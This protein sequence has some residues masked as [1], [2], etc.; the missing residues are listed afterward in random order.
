MATQSEDWISIAQQKQTPRSLLLWS[1]SSAQR[2]T[3][4]RTL[5]APRQVQNGHCQQAAE[6]QRNTRS[7]PERAP[8]VWDASPNGPSSPR[9]PPQVGQNGRPRGPLIATL[10]WGRGLP[11]NK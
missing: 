2:W 4:E 5:A 6:F 1:S 8:F 7:A 9:W 10:K 11:T 3:G